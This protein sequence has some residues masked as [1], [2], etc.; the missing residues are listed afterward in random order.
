MQIWSQAFLEGD[1]GGQG[2]Q[3]GPHQPG[4]VTCHVVASVWSRL[5]EENHGAKRLIVK[6][7]KEAG[8]GTTEAVYCALGSPL[9]ENRLPY[10]A[11]AESALFLPCWALQRL[12]LDGCGEELQVRWFSEEAFP[13]ATRIVLRPHDS[14]FYHVDAKEELERELTSIGVITEGSVIP[15]SLEALGGFVVSF[16]V[17]RTEPANIVLA[18][19]DEVAIEF[20]EALDAAAQA[21]GPGPGP[22]PGP[23]PGPGPETFDSLLPSGSTIPQSPA[24]RV[25]GGAPVRHM[26]DGRPW[27]PWRERA[28]I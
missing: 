1:H 25:L 11:D 22:A 10:G 18:E 14:A 12:G 20:E 15:V 2:G 8:D 24:G 26:P 4:A 16:E 27:N 21:P 6:I 28:T 19:G 5:F 7:S 3:G 23:A 17:I 13:E 9:Q